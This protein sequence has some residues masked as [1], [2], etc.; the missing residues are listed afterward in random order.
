MHQLAPYLLPIDFPRDFTLHEQGQLVD[1]VY[2]L[3]AGICSIVAMMKDG[4]TVEVGII[5]RDGFVGMPAILGTELSPNRCFM[6]ISGHGFKVKAKILTE[7]I[8]SSD[9]LRLCLLRSVQALIVQ[10]AQTAACNRVHELHERLARWLLMCSDRVQSDR[11]LITHEFLATMLGTRRSTV[12]VAVGIL[13]QAGLISQARGHVTINNHAGL[14]DA[15][16]ECYTVVHE[17]IVRLG[18]L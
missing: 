4:M 8:K 5:G 1:T 15:A 7:Q 3:E 13:Q 12:T 18:L 9:H 14:V 2:F 6:Q 17:E 16:C 10:T 11:L